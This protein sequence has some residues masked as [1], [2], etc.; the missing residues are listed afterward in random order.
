MHYIVKKCHFTYLKIE[1]ILL[2]AKL[3]KIDHVL[4]ESGCE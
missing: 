3:S 1:K 2:K 4:C